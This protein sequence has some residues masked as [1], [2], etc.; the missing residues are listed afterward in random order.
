MAN[1]LV[2]QLVRPSMVAAIVTNLRVGGKL[3]LS[4]IRPGGEVESLKEAYGEWIEWLDEDY[5]ELAAEDTEGA[6]ESF[7]FDVGVW[8]RLVGRKKGGGDR[9]IIEEMSDAA[10]M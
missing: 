8:A 9:S 6:M 1:I 7:G 10:L 3:C 4:G 5:G 2:G